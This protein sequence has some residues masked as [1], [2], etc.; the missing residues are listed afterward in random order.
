MIAVAKEKSEEIINHL[1]SHIEQLQ[2]EEVENKRGIVINVDATY[3]F[4]FNGKRFTLSQTPMLM[5][6]FSPAYRLKLQTDGVVLGHSEF[7]SIYPY[8][9]LV[10]KDS[11]LE[12]KLGLL[13]EKFNKYADEKIDET[14]GE[15]F[16]K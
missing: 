4:E 9:D 1:I 3:S 6:N 12:K 5:A 15:N 16:F 7:F 10:Y 14:L 8:R 13:V 11:D 2:V